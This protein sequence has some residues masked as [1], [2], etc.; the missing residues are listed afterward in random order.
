MPSDFDVAEILDGAAQHV[1]SD[2]AKAVD[3]DL[4]SH[5]FFLLDKTE[6]HCFFAQHGPEPY[7]L[8]SR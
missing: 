4:D 3:A 1:A 8:R 6:K 5:D 7:R 2:A